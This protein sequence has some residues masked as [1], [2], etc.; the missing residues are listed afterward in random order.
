MDDR[1]PKRRRQLSPKELKALEKQRKKQQELDKKF[2]KKAAKYREEARKQARKAENAHNRAQGSDPRSARKPERAVDYSRRDKNDRRRITQDE[3]V[4]VQ[5]IEVDSVSGERRPR[6]T[7]QERNIPERNARP[8]EKRDSR[9]IKKRREPE[10]AKARKDIKKDK[11]KRRPK[12]IPDIIEKET[13]K[14]VRNLEATDHKDGFYADEVEIRKEQARKQRRERRKRIP[15]PISPAKRRARKIFAYV[16]IIVIVLTVGI[17]LSLTVLFKTENIYVRGNK[18]YAND[19]IIRLAKVSEGD[20][21]FIA[22]MF[23]DK[24]AVRDSLPYVKSAAINFQLPNSIVINIE[25]ATPSYS[26]KTDGLY[27]KVSDENILLE[28]VGSKPKGLIS[29]I[30]PSLKSTK[31]G[32]KVEFKDDR[33]TKALEELT[34]CIKKNNYQKIT[35]INIRK[36]SDISITYDNRIKIKIGLPESIDYKLRTA[37]AIINEKLDP[38]KTGKIKGVL[39]VSK[40]DKTRKSY[41]K[42]GSIKDKDEDVT[43]PVTEITTEPTSVRTTYVAPIT[44]ATPAPEDNEDEENYDNNEDNEDNG[45]EDNDENEDNYGEDDGENDYDGGDNNYQEPQ[46]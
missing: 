13:D 15:K 5:R 41:F 40:C 14:R 23:G 24:N 30:A 29:M 31:I 18:Y 16:S 45:D 46:E 34:A 33:C 26:L 39:N 32:D 12:S 3:S 9:D 11:R 22:S 36:I 35:E 10:K 4:R 25:N 38:N 19:T 37:F 1:R 20:N 17:V 42:E 2:D 44:Q 27:Y 43:Q 6:R 28:Q 8:A 21:I 7:S